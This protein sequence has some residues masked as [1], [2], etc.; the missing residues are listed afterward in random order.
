MLAEKPGVLEVYGPGV[1]PG[2]MACTAVAEFS[3]CNTEPAVHSSSAGR[4]GLT[5]VGDW[6]RATEK[7]PVSQ[8]AGA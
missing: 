7:S 5:L 2:D 3:G 4:W 8:G 1:F 6:G